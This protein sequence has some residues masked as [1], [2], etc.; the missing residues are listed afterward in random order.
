M[1]HW[2][3]IGN[4]ESGVV[5]VDGVVHAEPGPRRAEIS[6]EVAEFCRRHPVAGKYCE[7][8]GNDIVGFDLSSQAPDFDK[9]RE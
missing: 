4:T 2:I 7:V 8:S 5:A 9:E 3:E 1:G 6:A